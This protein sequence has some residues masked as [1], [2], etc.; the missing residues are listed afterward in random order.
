MPEGLEGLIDLATDLR[1]TWSHA[2]D[3]LWKTLDREIWERTGNPLLVMQN[4]AQDHLQE[5]ARDPAFKQEVDRTADERA[6]Y[7]K[8]PRWFQKY[9]GQEMGPVVYISP[10]FG[11]GE[12]L[13]LYAGGL[14]ILAGD[15]LKTASDLGVPVVGVGIL[16]QEGYFRQIIDQDGWQVEVFPFNDPT[17]LPIRPAIDG[18]G[19]WLKVTLD[20][21]GR[22]L[23]LRVWEAHVGAV[24][25]YLLD[26]SDPLNSASDRGITSKLYDQRQEI[27]FLQE[28][29]LGIGGWRTVKA[30]GMRPEICHFNEGHAAFAILE[31]ARSF[32]E[33]EE[34]PFPVAWSATRGGNVF[35]TH[36]AVA[37]GFDSFPPAMIARYFHSY[38][39]SLGLSMDQ[40]LALGRTDPTSPDEPFNM[41]LLA[42]NGSTHING[43]SRLHGQVSRRIF[44]PMFPRWPES[45]V[46][47]DHITNG[48]H[49]P[50]WDSEEA[51]RLW[52]QARGETCWLVVEDLTGYIES[53]SDLEIWRL[54]VAERRSLVDYV[55]HRLKRQLQQNGASDGVSRE[56][57]H[58]LD[59][60]ALTLGFA[61]R[62]TSYK[63]PNLLLHDP[64]RLLR[65]LTNPE[66]PVQII[67]A[68]KAHPQDE[69]GKRM[70]QQ[71]IRFSN[72]S[73]SCRKHIVFLDDYDMSLA[74]HLVQGI[75]VWM[76]TPRRPWEACGTSGMKVLVNGGLNFSELDG[77]WAEAYSEA[78]GW[79]LCGCREDVDPHE[80]RT[81]AEM[82]YD[83]LE[84]EI[85]PEFYDR[86]S[87]GIPHR[88]AGRVRASMAQL[89]PQFSTNRMLQEYVEKVYLPASKRFRDRT[90][91][92]A[93]LARELHEWRTNTAHYWDKVH[94]GKMEVRQTDGLLDFQVSVYLG[95]LDS[96]NVRVEIYA[97]PLDGADLICQPMGRGQQLEG[98]LNGYLYQGAVETHRPAGHFSL[99]IVP[100][101]P[102][103]CIPLENKHILWQ[104]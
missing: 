13:P 64:Q 103:A 8:H 26:S 48:V 52:T 21:P 44:Q 9:A 75:D 89:T 95:E 12:A 102:H 45:H 22:K 11:L 41:A 47:V 17:V 36:T 10:E 92:R 66:R 1:W 56:A 101:H 59:A 80:D 55:R 99:R 40:L 5:L 91:D 77:W 15:Y 14:G 7:F 27:R 63:R 20:L 104:H 61:R 79:V 33:D 35:T 32:M 71:F 68:G 62:F 53:L 16:Y 57:E 98:V 69:E 73:D 34:Q 46:P 96:T 72:E 37:A 76:N 58:V 30:L 18:K 85:A 2:G 82:M 42:T 97:D 100:S 51:D 78:V 3:E 81:E 24:K 29:V 94:F 31:R 84:K 49:V 67:I 43:V 25:L 88:W 39:E 90:A 93:R 19:S 54:R 86:D 65:I 74:K 60:N 50:S 38:A 4:I 87:Q 28:M 83:I 70:I 23:L 6:N